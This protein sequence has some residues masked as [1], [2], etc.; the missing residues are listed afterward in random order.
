MVGNKRKRRRRKRK[1]KGGAATGG[2]ESPL[3]D[4]GEF[5]GF[6]GYKGC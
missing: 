6:G 2:L 5:L 1:E 4:I 3:V